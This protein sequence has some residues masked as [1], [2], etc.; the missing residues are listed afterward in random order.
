MSV[1]AENGR[2]ETLGVGLFGGGSVGDHA[3]TEPTAHQRRRSWCAARDGHA[4]AVGCEA[5][6]ETRREGL[7]K[8]VRRR[9]HGGVL[10]RVATA[11]D[12]EA[13]PTAPPR[14][15][16]VAET[17]RELRRRSASR[18]E[19]CR[20][21]VAR[22]AVGR[23]LGGIDGRRRCALAGPRGGGRGWRVDEDVEPRRHVGAR[24]LFVQRAHHGRGV[25]TQTRRDRRHAHCAVVLPQ[26]P[27]D[28]ARRAVSLRDD[29]DAVAPRGER[30]RRG[31]AERCLAA[32]DERVPRLVQ[33]RRASFEARFPRGGR[34]GRGEAGPRRR[35][36]AGAL[37][38]RR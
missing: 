22:Q 27:G 35:A 19:G 5:P 9:E 2:D 13:T 10:G 24:E 3:P 23:W 16:G 14:R 26:A 21:A 15:H 18:L 38:R 36:D 29:Y 20:D 8:R 17:P 12:D 31:R 1:A 32:G 28:G 30:F 7:G 37:G 25:A 6:A 33:R 34:S 4:D 11:A